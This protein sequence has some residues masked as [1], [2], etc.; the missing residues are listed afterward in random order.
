MS[1]SSGL[2]LSN[3]PHWQD[4]FQT[5]ISDMNVDDWA[6]RIQAAQDALMDHIEDSFETA[7]Q[8]ERQALIN[9]M[10]SLRELR[11]LIPLGTVRVL[12]ASSKVTDA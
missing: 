11:R 7:S 12:G 3:P 10:N 9:A 5:A 1:K 2:P 4:L 8:H 6:E